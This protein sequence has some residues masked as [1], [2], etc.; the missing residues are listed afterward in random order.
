MKLLYFQIERGNVFDSNVIDHV[1]YSILG[2][3]IVWIFVC[4]IN[5]H[6]L[7][8]ETTNLAVIAG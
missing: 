1:L 8:G 2:E 4:F 6:S 3:E 5:G 7:I